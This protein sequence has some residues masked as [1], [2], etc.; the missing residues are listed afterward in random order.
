MIRDTGSTGA[1][2][3]ADVVLGVAVILHVHGADHM[4]CVQSLSLEIRHASSLGGL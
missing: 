1:E 2:S 4:D 3:R